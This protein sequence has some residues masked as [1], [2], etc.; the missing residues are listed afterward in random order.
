MKFLRRLFLLSLC[1]LLLPARVSAGDDVGILI[2]S[3]GGSSKWNKT[4]KRTVKAAKISYPCRIFFGMGHSQEEVDDLHQAVN[5]LES[6]GVHQIII[7][8]LLIS[9]Y[10][11]IY[12]QWRYLLGSNVNPGFINNAFFPIEH[13]AEIRFLDPLNDD[14]IIS[15]ILMEHAVAISQKPEEESVIIV[16]H[17]PNDDTDNQKWLDTLDR[18]SERMR[19]QG[20]FNSIEGVTLRDDAPSDVRSQAI[21]IFRE[22]VEAIHARKGR[23][24][25]IPLLLAPGGIESK[26]HN[27]L[28]GLD[29]TLNPKTL[30][31]DSRISQWIKDKA[32]P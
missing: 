19:K 1:G 5:S 26:I 24:L 28:K 9:S 12:R 15:E 3:H 21:Q 7:I 17:G 29:Y 31:P 10:S 18:I 11:E 8:P 22:K 2:M 30:L 4:I 13:R 16:T 23:T 20:P 14:P 32:T 6:K 27:A 25:V